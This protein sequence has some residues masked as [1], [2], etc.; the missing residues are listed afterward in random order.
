MPKTQKRSSRRSRPV[1]Y[2]V[3]IGE[4][5]RSGLKV[6]CAYVRLYVRQ[7]VHSPEEP[8]SPLAGY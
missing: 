6:P 2:S 8:A 4:L 7:T 5:D 3:Y 1:V